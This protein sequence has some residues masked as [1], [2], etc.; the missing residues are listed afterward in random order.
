MHTA[1]LEHTAQPRSR[2]SSAATG[3]TPWTDRPVE[4]T[5]CAPASRSPATAS[6]TAGLSPPSWVSRV[7]SMSRATSSSSPAGGS[8][9]GSRSA[10]LAARAVR[11]STP[12]VVGP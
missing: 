10:H 5:T 11:G 4:S 7:P 9:A 2:P 8:E 12:F 6:R 3:S 1:P